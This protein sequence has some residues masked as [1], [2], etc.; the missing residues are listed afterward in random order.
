[1]CEIGRHP[2]KQRS[3]K[4][5]MTHGNARDQRRHAGPRDAVPSVAADR[6]RRVRRR[7]SPRS[8]AAAS[9]AGSPSRACTRR[10]SRSAFAAYQGARHG[11]LM[12]NGTVTMEVALQGARHRLGRR[13]DRPGADVQR[14]RVRADGRRRAA[15]VRRRHARHLDD[16]SRPGRG[17]DH[18]RARGRS[19]PVHL[20]HQMA[21]MDRIM[22]IAR[23]HGL[24]V[25]EDCAHAHGQRWNG[26]RRRVHRRLRLVQPPVLEDPH[27][28]R[29]RH[30]A[31][32]RRPARPA[33][34]LDHRLRPR[35]RT[36]TSRSTRSARTTGSA[37][38]TRRCSRSRC[39]GSP[40]Q[41][42]R[43][44]SAGKRFEAIGRRDPRR[45]RHAARTRAITRWSFYRYIV[46]ID[47]EAFAGP[48]ERGGLRRARG[49]GHRAEAGTSR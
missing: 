26:P 8:S 41:Q 17:G 24:A 14:H 44:P 1:M 48:D 3:R 21:D 34:P 37:S 42:E 33:R 16:R 9:G 29:G 25:I 45:A 49:R 4:E 15:G 32:E 13:G 39:D 47:P 11:V 22:E 30:A 46:A 40:R 10:R 36:P 12:S 18:R 35:R 43:A 20:G 27:R 28:G 23:R 7:R 5:L 2:P 6:R 38:C 31:H 19:C